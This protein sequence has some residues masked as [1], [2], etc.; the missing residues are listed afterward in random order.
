M[1]RTAFAIALAAVAVVVGTPAYLQWD[2]DQ[3]MQAS[4]ARI[5]DA[6]HARP[7]GSTT[8][9]D[10]DHYRVVDYSGSIPV[11]I[12]L[13]IDGKPVMCNQGVPMLDGQPFAGDELA[14]AV[15]ATLH[16]E[17]ELRESRNR[18]G[19]G[20]LPAVDWGALAKIGDRVKAHPGIF[21]HLVPDK[22]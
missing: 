5:A 6:R 13:W 1:A 7:L 22:Q 10:G 14:G 15:M 18:A 16:D 9:C 11:S 21:Q 4:Q 8:G 2:R 20:S 12:P 3:A 17:S 19:S